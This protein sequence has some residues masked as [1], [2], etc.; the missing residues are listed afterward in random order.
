MQPCYA[1]RVALPC[2][3]RSEDNVCSPERWESDQLLLISDIFRQRVVRAVQKRIRA[4]GLQVRR[5]LGAAFVPYLHNVD[6]QLLRAIVLASR[7]YYKTPH[8]LA[9]VLN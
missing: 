8:W 6:H 9:A 1:L 4:E 5:R 3:L 7:Y 2:H